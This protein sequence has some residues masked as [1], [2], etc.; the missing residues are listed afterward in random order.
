MKVVW[1]QSVTIDLEKLA[2]IFAN[3]DDDA[4]AQFFVH[5]AK[6]MMGWDG[7]APMLSQ[8]QF[9][10]AHLRN[11]KCST[12]EARELIINIAHAIGHSEHGQE[13]A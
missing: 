5:V 2:E 1:E 4:Q 10:G 6:I 11:C 7:L 9:I 8:A 13:A 12:N 3:L